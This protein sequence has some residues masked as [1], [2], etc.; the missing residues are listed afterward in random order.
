[1]RMKK[2][3]LPFWWMTAVRQMSK[4]RQQHCAEQCRLRFSVRFVAMFVDAERP[5]LRLQ[6]G[7]R[8]AEL[9]RSAFRPEH[10]PAAFL[11]RSFNYLLLLVHEF[12]RELLAIL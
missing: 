9:G 4:N 3:R 7:A 1:M 12:Q 11:Q 6:R 5:D 2:E 10:S 8:N